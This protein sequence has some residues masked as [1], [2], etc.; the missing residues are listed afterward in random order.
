VAQLEDGQLVRVVSAEGGA[1]RA[2]PLERGPG[3]GGVRLVTWS[4][5]A[6]RLVGAAE[7]DPEAYAWTRPLVCSVEQAA[8]A[9]R[10]EWVRLDAEQRGRRAASARVRRARARNNEPLRTDAA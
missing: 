7:G 5:A 9:A 2:Y 1:V 3:R 10:Q 6:L 8:E 4:A